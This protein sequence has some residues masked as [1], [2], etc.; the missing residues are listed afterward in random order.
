VQ[1]TPAAGV[2]E[3]G[4]TTAAATDGSDV[5]VADAAF[6]YTSLAYTADAGHLN[7]SGAGMNLDL[8]SVTALHGPIT[9]VN[10]NGTGANTL[11][12]NL[13]DVLTGSTI[14]LQGGSD[15]TV[16]LFHAEGW[17]QAGTST[18]AGVTYNVWHHTTSAEQ[19]LID[20]HMQV[21]TA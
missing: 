15:D 8:S 17:S 13:D 5:L 14:K 18:E 19:L 21:T 3:A 20:Q 10:L 4:R 12:I 9:E 7:L 6:E 16:A 1:R 2:T 11:K